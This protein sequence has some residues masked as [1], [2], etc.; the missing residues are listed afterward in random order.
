M[1]KKLKFESFKYH[2]LVTANKSNSFINN[3]DTLPDWKNF[4]NTL[5]FKYD[6]G[7]AH[8]LWPNMP[9]GN[10]AVF[11]LADT[12]FYRRGDRNADL[13]HNSKV[14]FSFLNNEVKLFNVKYFESTVSIVAKLAG[15][16]RDIKR[17]E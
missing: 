12:Q 5:E 6:N 1:A 16:H 14:E 15:Y 8:V 11:P 4:V 2:F 10:E 9:S 7:E 17:N 3:N 13:F